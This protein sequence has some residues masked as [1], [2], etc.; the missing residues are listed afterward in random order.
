MAIYWAEW[1]LFSHG[2][3]PGNNQDHAIWAKKGTEMDGLPDALLLREQ[4]FW[5]GWCCAIVPPGLSYRVKGRLGSHTLGP[6]LPNL[7][8]SR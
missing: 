5:Y 1:E 4:G 8:T 6:R 3:F 2:A 7:S